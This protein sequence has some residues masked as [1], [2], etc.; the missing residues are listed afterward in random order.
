MAANGQVALLAH[1]RPHDLL[2]ALSTGAARH[3]DLGVRKACLGVLQQ[4]L[5]IDGLQDF[6]AAA[7]V[8]CCSGQHGLDGKDAAVVGYLT[9]VATALL[10][11]SRVVGDEA[12]AARVQCVEPG[13]SALAAALTAARGE[14]SNTNTIKCVRDV[15]RAHILRKQA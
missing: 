4:L 13:G 9:E 12:L 5:G 3:P 10:A 8:T 7:V 1:H 11:V 15:L 6:V 14:V 2:H